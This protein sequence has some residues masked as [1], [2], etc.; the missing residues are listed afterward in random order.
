M[1]P[2]EPEPTDGDDRT[3]GHHRIPD[4]VADLGRPS[5]TDRGSSFRAREERPEGIPPAPRRR[6]GT[7]PTHGLPVPPPPII[8]ELVS[9]DLPHPGTDTSGTGLTGTG[10]T[11]S[12]P[13]GG[14]DSGPWHSESDEAIDRRS[15]TG[16]HG[17]TSSHRPAD[18]PAERP[19]RFAGFRVPRASDADAVRDRAGA[20]P[21]SRASGGG[22]GARGARPGDEGGEPSPTGEIDVSPDLRGFG[23]LRAGVAR[24]GG[25]RVGD[26]IRQ[27]GGTAATGSA[28]RRF[29]GTGE[30]PTID[31]DGR[32]GGPAASGG[33]ARTDR[34]RT[35]EPER[36]GR[37]RRGF[38]GRRG[39]AA[40]PNPTSGAPSV[41]GSTDSGGRSTF[42]G[43]READDRLG[44]RPTHG[45]RRDRADGRRP[46]V[47]DSSSAVSEPTSQ[48]RTVGPPGPAGLAGPSSTGD[49]TTGAIRPNGVRGGGPTGTQMPGGGP[50]GTRTP[51]GGPTGTRTPGGGPTGTRTPGGGP[52]GTRS[53]DGG[54]ARPAA[55]GAGPAS[56]LRGSGP[57]GPIPPAPNA[58]ASVAPGGGPSRPIGRAPQGGPQGAPQGGPPP[59][60][61]PGPA[62]PGGG[63]SGLMGPPAQPPEGSG[64]TV[65]ALPTAI[66]AAAATM[67]P[68]PSGATGAVAYAPPTPRPV[69]FTPP[70]PAP[71]GPMP[72]GAPP[73]AMPPATADMRAPIAVP[74][75]AY[76]DTAIVNLPLVSV[77]TATPDEGPGG[78]REVRYA[79]Q[80]HV[81]TSR[82]MIIAVLSVVVALIGALPALLLATEGSG[83]SDFAAIDHLSVP[84]W[85]AAQPV[86]H[87][88][89]NRWCLSACLKSERTV[90]ST[91]SVA[92]TAGA[93][94]TSLRAAGWTPA[95]TNVCPPAAK[96][97]AQS[98]WVL[99]RDQMNVMVTASSC[100]AP[101][102]P[103]TEP[104]FVDPVTPS[105]RASPPAGC[106]PTTVDISVFD[107]VDLRPATKTAR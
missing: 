5:R 86:D 1:T 32:S 50:T 58:P 17:L 91:R 15:E 92:E 19:S 42:G 100:A 33:D 71:S 51:G 99:D 83:N 36:S 59:G 77:D 7:P 62:T 79:N 52:T 76:A 80:V 78:K 27:R 72:A 61:L 93:Y 28:R 38:G 46:E 22:R 9:D 54:P 104:G 94:V 95:P 74:Q 23:G 10:L 18:V 87:T 24:L 107:R 65:A 6:R 34:R 3:T 29:G 68:G 13:A 106:A 98:C 56:A 26:A 11:G 4:D 47:D 8:K 69:P 40:Q 84:A 85:A 66:G 55:A 14:S 37:E 96:G 67:S 81:Q 48:L 21:D 30:Q 39:A 90:A 82:A 64:R 53:P 35:S 102:P 25:A 20:A 45:G 16:R 57:T 12:H 105:P 49:R 73:G 31:P 44:G 41:P 2:R 60:V 63:A 89:G 43:R 97:V 88:S 70:S 101:P 75:S 103:T